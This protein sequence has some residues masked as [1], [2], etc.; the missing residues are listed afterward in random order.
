MDD[1][2]VNR[3]LAGAICG[4][5]SRPLLEPH[6]TTLVSS[7]LSSGLREPLRHGG[8]LRIREHGNDT[9]D[10]PCRWLHRESILFYVQPVDYR[11]ESVGRPLPL[12]MHTMN[13]IPIGLVARKSWSECCP[14]LPLLTLKRS[15]Q[16]SSPRTP[17]CDRERTLCGWFNNPQIRSACPMVGSVH[18][19]IGEHPRE[20]RTRGPAS[21]ALFRCS[22]VLHRSFCC[23]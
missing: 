15:L 12:V 8:A 13:A 3:G 10:H 1:Y 9:I 4:K 6:C 2:R 18:S 7:A 11:S 16:E 23:V 5:P 17:L 14:S 19:P 20:S 22:E 21:D